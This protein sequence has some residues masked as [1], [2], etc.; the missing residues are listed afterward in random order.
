[1][2]YYMGLFCQPSSQAGSPQFH[3]SS[4]SVALYQLCA[5]EAL[6]QA[7]TASGNGDE[8]FSQTEASA[9]SWLTAAKYRCAY[10]T[11]NFA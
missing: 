6:V 8:V 10:N 9:G 5:S 4:R 3:R 2:S 7:A 11:V 1:M